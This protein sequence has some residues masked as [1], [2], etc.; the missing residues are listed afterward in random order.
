[1]SP[2]DL[3]N[4]LQA[5]LLNGLITSPVGHLNIVNAYNIS[6]LYS[7]DWTSV[8]AIDCKLTAINSE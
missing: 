7:V 4:E 1:M 8:I 2:P 6:K 3:I 5:A